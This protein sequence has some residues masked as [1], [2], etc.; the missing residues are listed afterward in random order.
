MATTLDDLT[1]ASS[2]PAQVDESDDDLDA[3]LEAVFDAPL[4]PSAPPAPPRPSTPPR[5]SPTPP[6]PRASP[7]VI[8]ASPERAPKRK[9]RSIL[10]ALLATETR[11]SKDA[12]RL[13]AETATVAARAKTTARTTASPS[14][15]PSELRARETIPLTLHPRAAPSVNP[16]TKPSRDSSNAFRVIGRLSTPSSGSKPDTYEIKDQNVTNMS[17][18]HVPLPE[19]NLAALFEYITRVDIADLAMRADDLRAGRVPDWVL[20]GCV[21]RKHSKRVT[22]AGKMY[23]VWS[24]C[25]MPR[26]HLTDENGVKMKETPKPTVVRLLLFDAAFTAFHTQVEGTVFA[27]RRP[28]VLPPRLDDDTSYNSELPG[29]PVQLR[30]SLSVARASQ[31][32]ALGTCRDFGLCAQPIGDLGECGAWFDSNL[33]KMCV[34]HMAIKTKRMLGGGSTR[35]EVAG[36]ERP[37]PRGAMVDTSARDTSSIMKKERP[38]GSTKTDDARRRAAHEQELAKRLKLHRRSGMMSREERRKKK[39]RTQSSAGGESSGGGRGALMVAAALAAAKGKAGS[40]ARSG[41]ES[42]A[43]SGHTGRAR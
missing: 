41:R 34:R 20:F 7:T 13:A 22:R 18:A 40:A 17:L 5:S 30:T 32:V 25:N 9:P 11:L 14:V 3:E 36:A 26:W 35:M 1:L 2:Q 8:P 19:P 38:D 24:F 10:D 31:V 15:P 28:T 37:R 6:P 27:L 21:V 42:T 4:P 23:A 29:A 16:T 12:A 43:K 33:R 39:A